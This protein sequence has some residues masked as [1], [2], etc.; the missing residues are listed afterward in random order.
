MEPTFIV[1]L[2]DVLVG[3][4]ERDRKRGARAT[5]PGLETIIGCDQVVS[6]DAAI[7]PTADAESIRIRDAHLYSVVHSSQQILHFVVAT[8]RK[9]ARENFCPRPELPY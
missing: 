7:T 3:S 1:V 6:Q 5:R 8:V 2:N 4:V 9:T